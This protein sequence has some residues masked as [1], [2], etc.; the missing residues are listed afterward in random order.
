MCNYT[1]HV[2][3][4]IRSII[5]YNV[6]VDSLF[7]HQVPCSRS[8]VFNSTVV[9]MLEKRKMMKFLSFCSDYEQHPREYE[10]ECEL[11]VYIYIYIYSV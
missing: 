5:I 8:D 4:Y 10:G 9:S 1:V 7:F 3:T 2:R 11:D 6:H